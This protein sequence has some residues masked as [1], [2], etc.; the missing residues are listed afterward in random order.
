MNRP[1]DRRP[2]RQAA[3]D[4][5]ARPRPASPARSAPTETVSF[6]PVRRAK[7]GELRTVLAPGFSL[8]GLVVLAALSFN[9]LAR[10][11]DLGVD[12]GGAGQSDP[13][14]A[15][16]DPSVVTTPPPQ[17]GREIAG[18]ILFVNGGNIWAASGRQVRRLTNTGVDSSP[19][20]SPDG[21]L[22]YFVE[23]RRTG[24]RAP[25]Q[26]NDSRYTLY[27]PVIMRM[28][29]DGSDRRVVKD[30]LYQLGGDRTRRYF[31]WL[32][33]PDVSPDGRSIALVSDAPDPFRREVTLSL[34]SVD[35]DRLRNLDLPDSGLGHNDPQWSPD[36]DL[37]AFTHNARRGAVGTP[38][39]AL[40]DVRRR[41]MRLLSPVGY[42]Q[43]SWSPDGR[44]LAAVRTT[45]RGR[46]IVV[47]RARDGEQVVR[48]TS[49]GRSFSPTWSPDGRQIAY[50]HVEGQA[51]DLR[52][53][54]IEGDTPRVVDDR[55]VTT[56]NR[57]DGTSRPAWFAAPP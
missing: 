20:W 40:Y 29:A 22:I 57:L 27:Y 42:A 8:I 16:P 36:G 1:S 11:P 9:L 45:G 39:V 47:L 41:R 28:N 31:T 7:Q 44:Y 49:D 3:R 26:G 53:M 32:L 48:L 5:A 21:R 4:P 55:A 46:D 37:I 43:P 13:I 35:G 25:W 10:A 12:Q 51:I 52:L 50:L 17:E 18:T 15:T 30:G 14:V 38:R 54:T 23:T 2:S 24:A 19:T 56:N 34:M 33:Q 6:E